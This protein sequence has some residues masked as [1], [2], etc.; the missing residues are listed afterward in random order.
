MERK[1]LIRRI[2]ETAYLEGDFVL[3]SGKRSRYYLDKYLFETQPDI[4]EALGNELSPLIPG[5]TNLLAGPE[6][7]GIPL[8]TVLSIKMQI[9][10]IIVR[11]EP[12][13]YG[14]SKHIEGILE[15]GDRVVVVEDVVTTGGQSITSAKVLQAAGAV[16]QKIVCVIDREEGAKA[17]MEAAGYAFEPLFTKTELGI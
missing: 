8:A 16:V 1:D 4:L 17:N 6:L 5:D 3:R 11:K 14:T 7:G 10:F 15:P 2:M 12:K 13:S 9:P